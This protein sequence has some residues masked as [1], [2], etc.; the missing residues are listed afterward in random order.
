MYKIVVLSLTLNVF[1]T[2]ILF[3]V[4]VVVIVEGEEMTDKGGE[5]RQC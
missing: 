5:W 1:V 2:I 3:K 4:M